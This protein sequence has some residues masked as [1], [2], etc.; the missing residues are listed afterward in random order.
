MYKN[1]LKADGYIAFEVGYNQAQ[2]VKQI[3]AENGY[4]N[5]NTAMDINGIERVV[6]GCATVG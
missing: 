2:A 6:Y 4:G 5:I 1:R 3:L